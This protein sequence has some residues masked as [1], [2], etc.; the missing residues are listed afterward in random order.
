MTVDEQRWAEVE[1]A[2]RNGVHD[3]Y[4]YGFGA[5]IQIVEIF[6]AHSTDP[7]TFLAVLDELRRRSASMTPEGSL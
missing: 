7:S 6:A 2:L 5:A 1:Q 3:A 4:R